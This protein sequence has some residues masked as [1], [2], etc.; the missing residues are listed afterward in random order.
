MK[1]KLRIV[2]LSDLHISGENTYDFEQFLKHSLLPDLQIIS[3]NTEVDLLF[4]SG[5]LLDK[6]GKGFS[7]IEEGF[8]FALDNVISPICES[9]NISKEKVFFAP[10]NH[11]IDRTKD[12]AIIEVGLKQSLISE[13]DVNHFIDEH[14]YQE[15]EGIQRIVPFKLF[16]KN[17]YEDASIEMDLSIFQS[18]FKTTI[19]D[20]TIGIVCLNSAWRCYSEDDKGNLLLGERQLSK[21]LDFLGDCDVKIAISHHSSYYLADFERKNID[22]YLTEEYQYLFLGHNHS[23]ESWCKSLMRGSSFTA[24]SRGN[25]ASNIRST[26]IEFLNGYNYYD[27]NIDDSTIKYY[28]RVYSHHRRQYVM[29]TIFL[30]DKGYIEYHL[31]NQNSDLCKLHDV[32]RHIDENFLDN[33]NSDIISCGIDTFAPRTLNGIFIEPRIEFWKENEDDKS[34]EITVKEII[35]EENSFVIFGAKE[36]G[37]TVLLDKIVYEYLEN[38]NELNT[39]PIHINFD[40]FTSSRLE[41]SIRKFLGISIKEVDSFLGKYKVVLIIDNISFIE[42]NKYKIKKITDFLGSHKNIKVICSCLQITEGQIPVEY[43]DSLLFSQ[44]RMLSLKYYRTKQIKDLTEKWYSNSELPDKKDKTE[45]IINLLRVLE[46]PRTPLAISMFLWIFE[47]QEDY[48]PI[49]QA[50]MIENFVE[51]MFKKHTKEETYF[52]EFN[53]K[54]KEKLLTSLTKKMY[55]ENNNNYSLSYSDTIEFIVKHLQKRKFDFDAI[56]L[57]DHFI[58]VGLFVKHYKNSEIHISFKFNCFFQYFLMKNMENKDFYDF[59]LDEEHYLS[60]YDEIDYFTAIKRDQVILLKTL[61]NRMTNLYS[62]VKEE[63]NKISDSYDYFFDTSESI[64]EQLDRGFIN[65]IQENK[66][67]VKNELEIIQDRMLESLTPNEK[68]ENKSFKLTPFQKLERS[69]SLVAKVLRNTE[70]TEEENLKIDAFKAV[71]DSSLVFLCLY[72]MMI[73]NQVSKKIESMTEERQEETEIFIRF[74]PVVHETLLHEAL[75]T[76]KLEM[77]ISEHINDI[78]GKKNVSDLEKM[79]SVFLYSDAK[80]KNYIKHLKSLVSNKKKKY[81]SDMILLKLVSYFFLRAEGESKENDFLNMIA[82]IIMLARDLP[83]SSKDK[84]IRSYKMKRKNY[85]NEN[86]LELQ[87]K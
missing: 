82:D 85:I 25:W 79:I 44:M 87:L 76:A 35:R 53:Y 86:Q 20:S 37:K 48:Q 14:N 77:V 55:D 16:E 32:A 64:A 43:F 11:D 33:V 59:V 7:S 61:I 69:W 10:G 84:I 83:K 39:I 41:T 15:H 47:K 30:G 36:T 22:N 3:N 65:S 9:L 46:L 51:R 75:T 63:I 29:D 80:G 42:S 28:V 71:L 4:F 12:S 34:S 38:I 66:E 13:S 52:N 5:D 57:L 67:E 81:S 31:N 8:N 70:E 49:N 68:V 1:R 54:N 45:K 23:P 50:V 19:N 40:D 27:I 60:F 21:S 73:I 24:V 72:K 17:F 26:N 2:H 62:I 58:E 18:S 78:I 56:K 6:G 74:L